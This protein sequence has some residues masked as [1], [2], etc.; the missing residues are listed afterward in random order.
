MNISKVKALW[1]LV[2]GGWAGL[3]TYI[4]DAINGWLATLDA[5]K[6]AEAAK[7]VMSVNA[8]LQ[9]ILD[10]FLPEKYKAAAKLTIAALNNLAAALAD[11]KLDDA[12]L[13]T[14]IDCVEVAVEAW[15][16]VK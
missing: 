6:L 16:E 11:G 4:L 3:A 2:T 1:S 15:K 13:D 12:E 7:I 14:Q 8:S 5:S 9:L 10:S